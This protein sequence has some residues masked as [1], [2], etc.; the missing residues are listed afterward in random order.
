M[1]GNRYI[2]EYMV[3]GV[4]LEV[5]EDEPRASAEPEARRRNLLQILF[6]E[7]AMEDAVN[8]VLVA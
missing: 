1:S 6:A 4:R 2:N 7:N 5:G 3:A 8:T